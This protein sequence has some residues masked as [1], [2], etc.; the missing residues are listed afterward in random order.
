MLKELKVER[1]VVAAHHAES[2]PGE[3]RKSCRR[4]CCR[5]DLIPVDARYR[6]R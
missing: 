5:Q 2:R 6:S 4:A 3:V 1:L